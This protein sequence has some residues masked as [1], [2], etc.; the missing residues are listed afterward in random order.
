MIVKQVIQLSEG[1][2]EE[3]MEKLNIDAADCE[4]AVD[5]LHS[6]SQDGIQEVLGR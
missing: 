3:P 2:A 6:A 5:T 1:C 4:R